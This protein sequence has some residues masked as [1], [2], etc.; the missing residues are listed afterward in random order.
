MPLN[1][2]QDALQDSIG[3]QILNEW[4]NAL[5]NKDI[6][7]I[8]SLYSSNAVLLPTFSNTYRGDVNS[9]RDYFEGLFK[10]EQLDVTLE[11]SYQHYQHNGQG[12]KLEILSGLYIFSYIKG[13]Q[14]VRFTAR[15]TFVIEASHTPVIQHHHSSILPEN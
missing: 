15:Y 6:S 13:Q 8:L 5:R 12:E 2:L 1:T 14:P 10:L 4:V 9:K 11:D 3:N 7:K